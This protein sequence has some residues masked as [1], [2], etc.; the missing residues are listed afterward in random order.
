MPLILSQLASVWLAIPIFCHPIWCLKYC[1]KSESITIC[2]HLWLGFRTLIAGC[3][4]TFRVKVRNF[5]ENYLNDE[6]DTLNNK[7]VHQ[8]IQEIL[9]ALY[10]VLSSDTVWNMKMKK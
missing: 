4:Y 9:T 1:S 5:I 7:F 6:N 2:Y 3:S 8:F 10:N